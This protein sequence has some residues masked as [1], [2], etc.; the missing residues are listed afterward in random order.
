MCALLIQTIPARPVLQAFGESAED[1]WLRE[2]SA[3]NRID[4][5]G[6]S[7]DDGDG[8]DTAS[9]YATERVEY[10]PPP[11]PPAPE[12]QTSW[13]YQAE[14][15]QTQAPRHDSWHAEPAPAPM[16]APIIPQRPLEDA[17]WGDSDDSRDDTH[18]DETQWDDDEPET[19]EME[20]PNPG[21]TRTG[22][23]PRSALRAEPATRRLTGS[24][25]VLTHKTSGLQQIFREVRSWM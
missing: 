15:R 1:A 17:V 25:I 2:T 23:R 10:T 18:D 24:A 21:A 8:V 19:A 3:L 22:Q 13:R 9:A 16:P 6:A 4:G 11:A 12:P 20:A 14:R 7:D 5:D